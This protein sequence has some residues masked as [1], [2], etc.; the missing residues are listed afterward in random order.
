MTIDL[1]FRIHFHDL[2]YSAITQN[3]E[4]SG[5]YNNGNIADVIN[6]HSSDPL[7]ISGRVMDKAPSSDPL[8]VSERAME[9]SKS[10]DPNRIA[11]Q[12]LERSVARAPLPFRIINDDRYRQSREPEI[13]QRE[14][15]LDPE[16]R[17][18]KLFE[19]RDDEQYRRYDKKYEGLYDREGD[20]DEEPAEKAYSNII[21]FRQDTSN[22]T[23]NNTS[24]NDDIDIVLE[25][26]APETNQ[27]KKND[28]RAKI[29][30]LGDYK[31]RSKSE[32]MAA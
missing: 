31:P 29:I 30:M 20:L 14:Y 4:I 16:N 6:S 22:T 15:M 12:A 1:Y 2:M 23:Y 27:Y 21:S 25:Y 17:A 19:N 10:S 18:K 26:V 9:N 24:P 13:K 7:T 28:H 5:D 8:V 3:I 11:R 32:R